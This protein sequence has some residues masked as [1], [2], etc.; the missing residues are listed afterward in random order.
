[1]VVTVSIQLL[2]I[3]E[4]IVSVDV[5]ILNWT[6]QFNQSSPKAVQMFSWASLEL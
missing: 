4:Y 2:I 5:V 3:E 6:S 1:M